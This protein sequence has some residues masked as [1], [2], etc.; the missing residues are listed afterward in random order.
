MCFFH[1]FILFIFIKNE[2]LFFLRH[3]IRHYSHY[4]TTH[5]DMIMLNHITT[6]HNTTQSITLSTYFNLKL[7]LRTIK[8]LFK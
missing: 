4:I 2:I 6:H 7:I 3:K 5:H 8:I 1:Y